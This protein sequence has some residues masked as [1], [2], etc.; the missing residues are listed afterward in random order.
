[1]LYSHKAEVSLR[2]YFLERRVTDVQSGNLP[3]D[4]IRL[5]RPRNEAQPTQEWLLG[6]GLTLLT[7]SGHVKDS[8]EIG[9]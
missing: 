7:T 5:I 6:H 2:D 1:M 3:Y 9:S 4:P 8:F